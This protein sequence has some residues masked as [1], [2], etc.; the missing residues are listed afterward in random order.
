MFLT[1]SNAVLNLSNMNYLEKYEHTDKETKEKEYGIAV[2]FAS[3]PN[4]Y[5]SILF[6]TEEERDTAFNEIDKAMKSI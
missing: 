5:Y 4:S 6:D 1:I 2:N 3:E